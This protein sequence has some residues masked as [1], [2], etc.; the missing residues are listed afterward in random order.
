MY[1][2]SD[3]AI[4]NSDKAINISSQY[5]QEIFQLPQQP[6]SLMITLTL[7]TAYLYPR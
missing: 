6:Y 2:G 4:S 7:W 3:H 5:L 1:Y